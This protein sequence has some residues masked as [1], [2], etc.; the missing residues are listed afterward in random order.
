M[1]YNPIEIEIQWRCTHCGHKYDQGVAV[2][3][4][5]AGGAPNPKVVGSGSLVCRH[6]GQLG[7]IQVGCAIVLGLSIMAGSDGAVHVPLP[8][9]GEAGAGRWVHDARHFSRN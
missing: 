4:P 2:C 7:P 8:V 5:G 9:G 3:M 6:C 1:G